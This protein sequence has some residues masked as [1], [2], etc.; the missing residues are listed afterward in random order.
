MSYALIP[1]QATISGV[2][3]SSEETPAIAIPPHFRRPK[4]ALPTLRNK[5]EKKPFAEVKK[6]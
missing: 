5:A 1:I 6:K 4:N 2:T 3:T